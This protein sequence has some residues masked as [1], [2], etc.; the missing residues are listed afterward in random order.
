MRGVKEKKWKGRPSKL[1]IDNKTIEQNLKDQKGFRGVFTSDMLPKKIRTFENGVV[2]LD[3]STGPGTHWVCYYNDPKHD[4][5]E[6][7][8]PFGEYQ[9]PDFKTPLSTVIIPKTI[10]KYLKT[11]GKPIRYNS[12][13]LQQPTSNRCG[14]YCMTYISERNKGREPWEVLYDFDQEPSDR[15]EN[16]TK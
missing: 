11:S 5:V 16:L 9:L 1:G 10:Q 3:V 15:N 6:Y 8:D 14:Y 4:F 12:S 13:F 2:N 7:F